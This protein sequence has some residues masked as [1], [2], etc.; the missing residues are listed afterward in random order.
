MSILT[1]SGAYSNITKLFYLAKEEKASVLM[2]AVAQSVE[3]VNV[4][5]SD[6]RSQQLTLSLIRTMSQVRVLAADPS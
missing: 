5:A 1:L 6:G 2:S 4:N 3:R